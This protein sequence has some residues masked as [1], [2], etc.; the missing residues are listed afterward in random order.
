MRALR[1]ASERAG[2]TVFAAKAVVVAVTGALTA[3]IFGCTPAGYSVESESDTEQSDALGWLL[4][5]EDFDGMEIDLS[6]WDL[7]S[8]ISI[9]ELSDDIRDYGSQA[10]TE[11]EW[12]AKTQEWARYVDLLAEAA[13]DG[14]GEKLGAS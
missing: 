12:R 2:G 11:E 8:V 10:H 5:A 1:K 9:E 3:S 13:A 14:Q 4:N 7:D 6:D